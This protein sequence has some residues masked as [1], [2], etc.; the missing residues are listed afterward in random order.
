ML[1]SR[2]VIFSRSLSISSVTRWRS[3]SCA[4][5]PRMVA[6]TSRLSA[7][8]ISRSERSAENLAMASRILCSAW[9]RDVGKCL[10]K[11]PWEKYA[12]RGMIGAKI[13]LYHLTRTQITMT[14]TKKLSTSRFRRAGVCCSRQAVSNNRR[15][16]SGTTKQGARRQG[17]RACARRKT[18]V[19]EFSGRVPN[20]AA[21][22]VSENES[23]HEKNVV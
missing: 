22:V 20:R 10:P 5:V 11:A 4:R 15:C 7:T 2:T 17:E 1:C 18:A 12:I 23:S 14:S 9:L 13:C 21:R 16:L 3:S 8:W 19:A 6:L